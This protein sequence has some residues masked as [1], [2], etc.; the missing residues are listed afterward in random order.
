MIKR[1]SEMLTMSTSC[2]CILQ[3]VLITIVEAAQFDLAVIFLKNTK[4]E[5]FVLSCSHPNR[6]QKYKNYFKSEKF[7]ACF[8]TDRKIQGSKHDLITSNRGEECQLYSIPFP[9]SYDKDIK[10]TF[11]LIGKRDVIISAEDLSFL[12]IIMNQVSLAIDNELINT[13]TKRLSKSSLMILDSFAEGVMVINNQNI[14]FWNQKLNCLIESNKS[15]TDY[16]IEQFFKQLIA[17]SKDTLNTQL[18]IDTLQNDSIIHYH[19]FIETRSNK[20]LRIKKYP[21]EKSHTS[22][23]WGIVVSDFTQYKE[24]DKLKDDLIAT[25]SHE[26]RTPLTSIKGNASALLRTDINWPKEDQILFL[27][28]IYEESDHLN[29]LI[30]K[31]LDFSK[32]NAGALRIDPIVLTVQAFVRNLSVQL[33]KRYKE[34]F[35]QISLHMDIGEERIEIDE[36][37]IIQVIFNLIDNGFKHNTANA[38]IK[39]NIHRFDHNIQITVSDN[40]KGIPKENIDKIFDKYYQKNPNDAATGFGL[41][42]A[43]SKGF[44]TAHNGEIW[45]E[46]SE[47][48]GSSF[49]FSIPI[50]RR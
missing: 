40:G 25:V 32:I 18:A 34:R 42:L 17:I 46:S 23:T 24:S 15:W 11:I 20:Y 37:R 12:K 6:F 31:L 35:S 27:E 33:Q 47:G 9:L 26:L 44:I 50:V 14:F 21:L 48:C 1:L 36:Q 7:T 45:V 8:D 13:N 4:E 39:V 29:D 49:H 19:F 2:T 22:F 30:G 16:S 41:G 43:I 38:S 10:C 3:E 28:D 5:T